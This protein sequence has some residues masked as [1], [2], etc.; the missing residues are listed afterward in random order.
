MDPSLVE[1]F[2]AALADNPDT[3]IA[4]EKEI[5]QMY[6]T[7]I[8]TLLGGCAGLILSDPPAP[9]SAVQY[10]FIIITRTFDPTITNPLVRIQANWHTKMSQEQRNVLKMAIVRGLMFPA[11]KIWGMAA[12]CVC[13][14]VAIERTTT[15]DVFS[16]L[17]ELIISAN[18]SES[19]HFAA[20]AALKEIYSRRFVHE[21]PPESLEISKGHVLMT[22]QF[23][24]NAPR[25]PIPFIK[26]IVLTL[27]EI[28]KARSG[29]VN[30][31]EEHS[32]IFELVVKLLPMVTDVELYEAV[33]YLLLSDVQVFYGNPGFPLET[34]MN[35]VAAGIRS[36]NPMFSIVSLSFCE[37]IAKV[38]I[39]FVKENEMLERYKVARERHMTGRQIEQNHKSSELPDSPWKNRRVYNYTKY[40]AERHLDAV[41]DV[42]LRIDPQETGADSRDDAEPYMFAHSL[43]RKMFL[44]APEVIFPAVK[45]LYESHA[46]DSAWVAQHG[47]LVAINTVCRKEKQHQ[48]VFEFLN[49]CG[50]FIVRCTTSSVD[51]LA[52]TALYTLKSAIDCYGL[53]V[54]P[55]KLQAIM[56]HV[57][58]LIERGDSIAHRA[59]GAL[60][61]IMRRFEAGSSRSPLLD[62]YPLVYRIYEFALSFCDTWERRELLDELYVFMEE[63]ICRLPNTGLD[64]VKQF[65]D[66]LIESL[67]SSKKGLAT[68]GDCALAIYKQQCWLSTLNGVF[69]TYRSK[70][71][72][73][74]YLCVEI[75]LEIIRDEEGPVL[76]DALRT[77][78]RIV[79]VIGMATADII[80][81]IMN[82][83]TKAIQSQVPTLI[84]TSA[85][86][87][88][89]LFKNATESMIPFLSQSVNLIIGCIDDNRFSREF[90]P[91]LTRS[92]SYILK[93]AATKI[94][95][96]RGMRDAVFAV[97]Q[98]FLTLPLFLDSEDAI[99]YGNAIFESI[100]LGYAAVIR[101]SKDDKEF[102]ME[103]RR[104]LFDPVERYMRM[105]IH[106]LSD[107]T[108]FAFYE[109]IQTGIECLPKRGFNMLITRERNYTLVLWGESSSSEQLR[110]KASDLYE[111]MKR[112]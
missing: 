51:R 11:Q 67:V 28:L 65:L 100:F 53:F 105:F 14:V 88:G 68:V 20:I 29:Q 91:N 72:E 78:I 2:S 104:A 27:A 87:L 37:L 81:P 40:F 44:M 6:T 92:L 83:V 61:S 35:I 49:S 101:A 98:R 45:S 111:A 21:M 50:D 38:E 102:L 86:L 34:V 60:T 48:Q 108:L 58:G 4:A 76:D 57:V 69:E 70:V 30:F 1:L 79:S 54:T 26:E 97:Y 13:L 103:N 80:E 90:Y 23:I 99:E 77:L 9:E 110:Q 109:F 46:S 12:H 36:G 73:K 43:L 7:D 24:S 89:N 93:S 112:C 47:L 52:D 25:F 74:A 82:A 95:P 31:A 85:L 71:V 59:F 15:L 94:V 55:E 42:L 19:T 16:N 84:S 107:D 39:G 41:L 75:L 18:Y 62:L 63:Y 8:V 22:Y 56:E 106:H 64:L 32:R 3:R 5:L 33:H 10:S 96:D 17:Q 66:T